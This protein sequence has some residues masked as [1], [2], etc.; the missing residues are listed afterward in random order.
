[1]SFHGIVLTDTD[2][3][4]ISLL[5]DD[6]LSKLVQVLLVITALLLFSSPWGALHEGLMLPLVALRALHGSAPHR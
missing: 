6:L 2:G 5:A 1:M 3:L 4:C